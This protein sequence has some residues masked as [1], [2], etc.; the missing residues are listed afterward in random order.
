MKA[1][2][3][4]MA[5]AAGAGFGWLVHEQV[6]REEV[7]MYPAS[8][9]PEIAHAYVGPAISPVMRT[10]ALRDLRLF[11]DPR[12]VRYAAEK[13]DQ[14]AKVKQQTAAIEDQMSRFTSHEPKSRRFYKGDRLLLMQLIHA[15]ITTFE[16]AWAVHVGSDSAARAGAKRRASACSALVKASAKK[17]RF[18]G[19]QVDQDHV[20][21]KVPDDANLDTVLA[22][23]LAYTGNQL[24][25][26]STGSF[27][28]GAK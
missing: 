20:C 10:L 18:I 8:I 26:G 9:A 21:L 28:K 15:R 13:G 6:D 24:A 16:S 27:P 19:W 4:A 2:F 22:A 23:A 25:S 12:E 14:S 1:F 5:I 3:V 11:I 7:I 17:G